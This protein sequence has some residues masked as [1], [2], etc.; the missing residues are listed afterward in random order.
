MQKYN[1][2][3]F[4]KRFVPQLSPDTLKHVEESADKSEYAKITNNPKHIDAFLKHG[5]FSPYIV[6]NPNLT[7][8]HLETLINHPNEDVRIGVSSHANASPD[9]LNRLINDD[10][11]YVKNSAIRNAAEKARTTSNSNHIDQYIGFDSSE[12]KRGA[13][14]NSNLSRT[15]IDKLI[16]DPDMIVRIGLAKHKNASIHQL[17]QLSFDRNE[18]VSL[19]AI[20]NAASKAR[21]TADSGEI[22]QFI[23]F[24]HPEVTH[25]VA[26]NPNLTRSHIDS[27]IS[28]PDEHVRGEISMLPNTTTEHL[29]KLSTDTS[30]AVRRGALRN[31]KMPNHILKS[32]LLS[33]DVGANR[34]AASTAM[35][36]KYFPVLP[37]RQDFELSSLSD[38]DH[39]DDEELKSAKRTFNFKLPFFISIDDIVTSKHPSIVDAATKHLEPHNIDAKAV[40]LAIHKDVSSEGLLHL[41]KIAQERNPYV[42]LQTLENRNMKPMHARQIV[43]MFRGTQHEKSAKSA[44]RRNFGTE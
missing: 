33:D 44:F 18:S 6:Y 5:G 31:P 25:G 20:R 11:Q 4:I 7:T 35:K 23:N 24:N 14:S 13:T 40:M 32:A 26:Q 43:D 1:Q 36:K 29:E 38:L 19:S 39:L 17:K 34:I 27:L 10:N 15:H 8:S 37:Q 28:N 30:P 42:A 9:Q 41:A 12:V 16:S 21:A 2:I 3:N 22:N